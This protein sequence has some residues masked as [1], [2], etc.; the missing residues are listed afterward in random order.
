MLVRNEALEHLL[1]HY[2]SCDRNLAERND[3]YWGKN[4][5]GQFNGCL[6]VGW[7]GRGCEHWHP[8]EGD[9][10]DKL[11]SQHMHPVGSPNPD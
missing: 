9:T 3:C 4:E 7:L 5:C 6:K 1:D 2:G 11:L 8:I 10:L